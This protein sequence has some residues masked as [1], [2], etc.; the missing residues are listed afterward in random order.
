MTG[1]PINTPD[2]PGVDRTL[3][4]STK[5][6][7]WLEFEFCPVDMAVA[8]VV[9]AVGVVDVVD[10]AVEDVVAFALL[11]WPKFGGNCPS[12]PPPGQ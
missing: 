12:F 8:A 2:R 11:L 6:S 5:C 3:A 4:D 9:G 10:G 1:S 7:T